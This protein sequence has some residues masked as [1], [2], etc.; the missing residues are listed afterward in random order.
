YIFMST[1][2]C[3]RLVS[4]KNPACFTTKLTDC[5]SAVHM[6]GDVRCLVLILYLL[7]I[8]W[9][10]IRFYGGGYSK[11]LIIHAHIIR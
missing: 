7:L 8:L 11:L 10:F 3:K 4:P 2:F 1:L 5:H 9:I 6:S